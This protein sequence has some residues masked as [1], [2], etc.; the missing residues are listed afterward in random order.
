MRLVGIVLV[1]AGVLIL[2]ARWAG[3]A[4][5]AEPGVEPQ[6]SA[7]AEQTGGWASPVV[8]GIAVVGGLLL[9]VGDA[10]RE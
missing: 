10:R 2:G 8:G 9:L 7:P 4:G 1:I 6:A 3:G 5:R